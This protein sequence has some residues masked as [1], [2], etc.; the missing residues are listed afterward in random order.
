MKAR[1]ILFSGPMV[2]A[3]LD[4][5]KTQTRRVV[6]P[7]PSSRYGDMPADAKALMPCKEHPDLWCIQSFAAGV[8]QYMKAVPFSSADGIEYFRERCP[9]GKPGDLLWVRESWRPWNH[10]ELWYCVNYRADDACL[11]PK[12]SDEN[13]G[14]KFEFG[15]DQAERGEKTSWRP[16][17]HMPRWASR[18]TLEI[19][20]VRVEKLQD[21]SEVDAVAEGYPLEF[22]KMG[23]PAPDPRYWYTSAWETINGPMSWVEN[24]WVWVI[25]F[26]VHR[27]NI[28]EFLKARAA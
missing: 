8:T 25:E 13:E 26:A 6:K 16:S 20:G 17:I 10:E 22:E 21:I 4:G 9:Y 15:C 28:D 18:L 2:R 12:I 23:R 3:L 1:P 27:Q 11:K 14:G 24:P 19:T 7:Q 5:R